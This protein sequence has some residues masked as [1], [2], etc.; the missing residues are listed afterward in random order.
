MNKNNLFTLA[1]LPILTISLTA[2]EQGQPT[3][4]TPEESA[5]FAWFDSHKEMKMQAF[6]QLSPENNNTLVTGTLHSLY[7][8]K[9][10]NALNEYVENFYTI[11]QEK[12][13][14]LNYEKSFTQDT[15]LKIRIIMQNQ[16]LEKPTDESTARMY[17]FSKLLDKDEK[18]CFLKDGYLNS[19]SAAHSTVK[20]WANLLANELIRLGIIVNTPEA[21]K[22]KAEQLACDKIKELD[23]IYKNTK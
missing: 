7:P 20:K 10:S 6:K 5:C 3:T 23:A 14:S 4:L 22:E 13:I 21:K 12:E 15:L 1:L 18:N 16:S 9:V 8:D 2:M 11:A 17:V 19:E